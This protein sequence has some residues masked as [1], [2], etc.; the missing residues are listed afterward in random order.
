M[1]NFFWQNGQYL[2]YGDPDEL[3]SLSTQLHV[4]PIITSE[5]CPQVI[6]KLS[7][8]QNRHFL[9]E[10]RHFLSSYPQKPRRLLL[11]YKYI[12]IYNNRHIHK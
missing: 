12:Y 11:L 10:V 3:N 1:D 7:T 6:H 9:A 8:E 4:D 5:G 2:G